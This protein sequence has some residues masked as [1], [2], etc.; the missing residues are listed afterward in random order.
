M[1]FQTGFLGP[2]IRGFGP[3]IPPEDSGLDYRIADR[4]DSDRQSQVGP[5]KTSG[6]R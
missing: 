6:Y 5:Q 1:I 4:F 2:L 3:F